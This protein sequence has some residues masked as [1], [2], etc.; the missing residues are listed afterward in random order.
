M[1]GDKLTELLNERGMKQYELA[2]IAGITRACVCRLCKNERNP[3][4]TTLMNV[5]NALGVSPEYFRDE[6]NGTEAS[7]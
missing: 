2:E 5:C 7:F 3:R 4:Y 6:K 1:F